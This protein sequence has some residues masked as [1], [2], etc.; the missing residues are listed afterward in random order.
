[1][2]DVVAQAGA[3][4]V[5]VGTTNR[6]RL[7]DYQARSGR[8]RAPSCGRIR[9]TSARWGSSRTWRSRR[10]ARLGPPVIDDVGSGVL[11]DEL[12]LLAGEPPVRRSVRA[13][14]AL[15]ALLRRQAAGRPAGRDPGRDARRGR[16]RARAIRSRARSGSTSCRWRRSRRRWR[17]TAIPALARRELPVLAMLDRG[18]GRAARAGGAARRGDGRRGRRGGRTRGR[19]RPAAPGAARPGGRARAWRGRRRCA[20]RARCAAAI[21]RS[22]PASSAAE[23]CSTRGRSRPRRSTTS[24]PRWRQRAMTAAPLTL[25]TAGHIDHGKTALVGALTGTDT[26][27]LPGGEGPRDLDRAR[28]RAARPARR[29]AAVRRRRAGARALRADD[30]RRRDGDRSV[31]DGRGR[32]RRRDAADARARGGARGA[33]RRDRGGRRHEGRRRRAGARHGRGGGAPARCRGGGLLRP[34]RRGRGGRARGAHR[35]RGGAAGA[36]AAPA[37]RRC[38]TWTACSPC[39]APAPWSPGHCGRGRSPRGTSWRCAPAAGARGCGRC[40]STTS[41]S[42]APPR[43]SGSR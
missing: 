15:V 16:R 10:C 31:S 6:T 41:R 26:D 29:P 34:H 33:R 3:R 8:T 9:R 42:I 4:L 27:R 13:G 39:A 19:R 11:G 14:A 30:G 2:P 21:L 43:G 24:P 18:A 12:E 35:G 37:A 25:G 20:G 38:S 40:T 17:C 5:E 1:M 22:S 23:S 28:L 32:R 7:A 36:S